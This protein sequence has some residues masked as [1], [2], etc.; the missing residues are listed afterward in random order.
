MMAEQIERNRATFQLEEICEVTGGRPINYRYDNDYTSVE[1]VV[2]DSRV[3]D[4]E[5][6]ETT[7]LFIALRGEKFDG[8]E[9]LPEISL[10]AQA[11]LVE[12]ADSNLFLAQIEV[13]DTL[14]ALGDL[15]RFHRK[16]F[17]IPIVA[18]TGSYGKTSTRALIHAALSQK[19]DTL[20]SQG[21][22][23]NEI[24]LPMTLFQLES[25][26]QA[27]VLEMGMRGRGQIDYLAKIAE[28]TVGVITNIGPQHIELLG[29]VEEIAAAKAELL[30]NLP[31]N[32]LAVLPADSPFLDFLMGQTKCK[33]VTFGTAV[34]ADYRAQNIT[35][36]ADGN[37]SCEINGHQI[38]LPLPGAHNATNAAAAFAVALELGVSAA[39]IVAGLESAQLPGARM[40]VGK[41]E[42]GITL[43]DDCYNAG[44]DSTRAAL[45]TL[46]DFPGSGRRV[47]VLGA[48]KEL[49]AHSEAEHVKI[50][51][52]A[53][54]F[55]EL[56]VGVGGDTRPLLDGAIRAAKAV[57][58]EMPT[59]YCDDAAEAAGRVAEWLQRGDVVLVKGSRSIGLEVVVEAVKGI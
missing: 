35:T 51:A 7:H 20:T 21:N 17:Q 34:W 37:I 2:T 14:R 48:M 58:N 38:N 19:F 53:G 31:E 23:N 54:Q 29:S 27:A 11:A 28:P 26:H 46:L 50:G 4:L 40:R 15:A 18:V 25:R 57:E 9:F 30:E 43:I 42:N 36:R 22:F 59:F 52:L 6:D 44:P 8:H 39:Q 16:R 47:A 3:F 55:V 32:G 10:N 33:A 41:L 12:N 5:K 24:G 49:G 1:G 56:L 45:Q 13:P